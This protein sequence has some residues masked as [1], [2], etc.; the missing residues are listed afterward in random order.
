M[1]FSP[2]WLTL[3]LAG[4]TTILLLI[5]GLPVAWWL[6]RGRS[7]FKIIIEALITI[8][9]V[10]PPSVLGFYILVAFS[11]TRG[12]GKWL[13]QHLNIQ[14]VFSFQGLV[15]ASVIYS[16]PFMIGPVKS[17]LQQLP[18]SLSQ[19]SYSLGKTQWQTFINILVPNIKP[20]LLTAAVLTFA[21]TLGEFG[22]V[23]MI[24]GDIPN[25][26]RVASIAVYDA[27]EQTEY[28]TANTYSFILFAITFVM[29]TSVFV[30]NK[31][32]LKSPLE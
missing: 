10:L 16:M 32:Q 6:S 21:H 25:V 15:L 22:V 2:I 29:V 31:Y 8:P 3:K 19:A 18:V 30:F 5:I 17:A 28:A 9:L 20:S 4:I 27:V 14:F 24:G 13:L 23:L 26:T 1:D 7:F 11:P 12:L